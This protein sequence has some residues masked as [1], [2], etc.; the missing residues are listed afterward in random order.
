M[1]WE[2]GWPTSVDNQ[3]RASLSAE[4]AM[5]HNLIRSTETTLGAVPTAL[6]SYETQIV[7]NTCDQYRT[8]LDLPKQVNSLRQVREPEQRVR[9]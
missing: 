1:P 2:S 7:S 5:G 8:M 3:V 6:V 4:R 9:K